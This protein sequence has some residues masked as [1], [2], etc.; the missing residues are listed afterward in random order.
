[1]TVVCLINIVVEIYEDNDFNIGFPLKIKM[2]QQLTAC[3]RNPP[4]MR[5]H[6]KRYFRL[7]F[8]NRFLN[9]VFNVFLER[10]SF[11]LDFFDVNRLNEVKN[12]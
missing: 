10:L 2:N 4:G 7:F 11:E 6:S 8:G 12:R 3:K 9:E 1:V 5:L